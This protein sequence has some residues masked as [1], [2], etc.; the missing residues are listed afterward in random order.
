MNTHTLRWNK[1]K[2]KRIIALTKPY[3]ELLKHSRQESVSLII[4]KLLKDLKDL[5]GNKHSIDNDCMVE[6]EKVFGSGMQPIA[7]KDYKQHM[8]IEWFKSGYLNSTLGEM[9]KDVQIL[10]CF[11]DTF[12]K[13]V[14]TNENL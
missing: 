4:A 13:K 3:L 7:E 10:D 2:T 12:L 8:I 11:F 1:S 14:K 6:L 9:E 5:T